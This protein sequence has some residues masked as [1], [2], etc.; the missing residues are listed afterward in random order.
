MKNRQIDTVAKPAPTCACDQPWAHRV[1][2][3]SAP[4]CLKCGREIE[5]ADD[6]GLLVRATRAAAVDLARAASTLV[7]TA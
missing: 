1:L 2:P 4:D 3:E 5:E 6:R 7:A